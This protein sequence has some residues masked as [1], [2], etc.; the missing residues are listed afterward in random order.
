MKNQSS[1]TRNTPLWGLAA[2]SIAILFTQNTARLPHG[3]KV[4][5]AQIDPRSVGPVSEAAS[6]STGP[7]FERFGLR[8]YRDA[9]PET[10][11]YDNFTCFVQG[12]DHADDIYFPSTELE[13][14]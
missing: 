6:G 4:Q 3:P 8:Y 7:Y 13:W 5:K 12:D 2:I 11:C 9:Y 1:P 14:I 10:T